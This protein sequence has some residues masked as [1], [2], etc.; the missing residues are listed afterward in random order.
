MVANNSSLNQRPNKPN[1]KPRYRI[2]AM[3]K[4][5]HARMKE[6][7]KARSKFLSVNK[8]CVRCGKP[9]TEIHHTRGRVGKLL[10][11]ECYWAAL[12]RGCHNW[13]GDNPKEARESGLLC[14]LGQWNTP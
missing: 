11:M 6:Y 5:R 12:D 9:A 7:F 8:K 2:P 1:F 4:V 10:L 3:S 13:V 14:E